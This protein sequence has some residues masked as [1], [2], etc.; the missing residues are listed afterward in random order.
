M[1]G[2]ITVKLTAGD[3]YDEQLDQLR[4]AFFAL[5]DGPEQEEW[6]LALVVGRTV[7]E[8][9][10]IW[11]RVKTNYPSYKY[12][13]FVSRNPYVLDGINPEYVALFMLPGCADNPIVNDPMFRWVI[14]NAYEVTCVE[15]GD[16]V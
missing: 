1:C 8:A 12:T 13:Q 16:G 4:Q 7:S 6:R 14:D 10:T 15:E 2:K 5:S 9:K 3:E 11:K